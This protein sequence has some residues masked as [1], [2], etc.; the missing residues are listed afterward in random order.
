VANLN[1]KQPTL[2]QKL[3]ATSALERLVIVLARS[4][5]LHKGRGRLALSTLFRSSAENAVV[6]LQVQLASGERVYVFPND[7][8]GRMVRFFGD[9][10]PALSS[11]VRRIVRRD[12]FVVDVGANVGI[13]TLQAASIAGPNGHVF[14]FEPV[15][16][17]ADL[18][19][20]SAATNDL[21]N[22]TVRKVALSDRRGTGN[23]QVIDGALGC[24]SLADR[25]DGETCELQRLDDIDFGPAFK[26]P[27][28]L[29]IDVEG[30][31]SQV[32]AG[33]RSFLKRYCP[34]YVLFES[35][36]SRGDFWQRTEVKMLQEHGYRFSAIMRTFMGKP[37][38]REI[39]RSDSA[40]TGSYDFL[41]TRAGLNA[42]V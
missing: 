26:H 25:G 22:I 2:V 28:L 34:D 9:L 19:E 27:R 38:L 31:E 4:Y 14:A 24:S 7:Y 36:A 23:M 15:S 41:A 18:L 37:R 16:R 33:A 21:R 29:K 17:L 30:H 20:Q 5:P 10:D 3:L 12:D 32:L 6:P 11:V 42:D 13:V 40:I 35:H 39:T 8:I 1:S